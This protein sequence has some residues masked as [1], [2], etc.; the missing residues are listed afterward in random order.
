MKLI[1]II[2][3]TL[4]LIILFL[5][6]I[7]IKN[8]EKNNNI[9]KQIQIPKNLNPIVC[10]EEKTFIMDYDEIDLDII[11]K[12]S[13]D[14]KIE[15]ET[16]QK[17]IFPKKK[18]Y[19]LEKV[20]TYMDLPGYKASN[21]EI[22]DKYELKDNIRGLINYSELKNNNRFMPKNSLISFFSNNI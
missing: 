21:F 15:L 12:D 4:I 17:P 10:S 3:I 5:I 11:N 19:K 6:Y 7:F 2:L 20:T 9:P 14:M 13:L 1:N 22:I 8:K 18:I 16:I